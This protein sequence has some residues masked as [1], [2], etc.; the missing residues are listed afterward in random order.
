[1]WPNADA[2]RAAELFGEVWSHDGSAS[3]RHQLGGGVAAAMVRS[4]VRL[5]AAIERAEAEG[6][7]RRGPATELRAALDE[8]ATGLRARPNRASA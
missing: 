6:T 1:M 2:Y 8:S 4:T 3:G 7:L 5:R